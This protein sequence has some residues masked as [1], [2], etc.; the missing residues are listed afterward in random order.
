M[1]LLIAT[2]NRGKLFEYATLLRDSGLDLVDLA[3]LVVD[4]L[5]EESGTTYTEN[6][7][8]KARAYAAT[9]G[10]LTLADDSGLEA[11]TR[12]GTAV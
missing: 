3:D 1:R 5:V 9:T 2:R 4:A 10:I 8:L 11:F 6:A 7:L 12:R